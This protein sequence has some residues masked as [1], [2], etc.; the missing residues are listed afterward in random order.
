M[1]AP[2]RR[3]LRRL[4][5]R[6]G[7]LLRSVEREV[8]AATLPAFANH[9][10]NLRI[11][12]PRTIV[13]PSCITIGDQVSLG[14]GC[15]LNAIRRYPGAWMSGGPDTEPQQFEPSIVIGDRVSATGYLTIGAALSVT[16]E[17]DVLIAGH[18]FIS[19]NQHGMGGGDVPFKYQPLERIAPV[20]IGRGTWLGEHVVVLS[21]VSIG[22]MCVIGANSVVTG[23]I[24]P[25]CVAVGSPARVV[26]R[27]DAATQG[28]QPAPG[29]S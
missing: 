1:S 11:E 7:I 26:R 9:P 24:P 13:N 15:Q 18:V 14:P 12:S 27:W 21:G 4:A 25:R 6:L 19:D 3:F 17:D 22:E 8:D 5:V 28:W 10:R 20:R 29:G 2:R 23:S 16:I